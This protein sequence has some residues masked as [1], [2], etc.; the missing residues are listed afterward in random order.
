MAS[1][2][3]SSVGSIQPGKKGSSVT[4]TVMISD[5]RTSPAEACSPDA[6]RARADASA[7]L[8]ERIMPVLCNN[9]HRPGM[10]RIGPICDIT[11]LAAS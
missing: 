8:P 6:N 1:G 11:H 3:L 7:C 9:D 4:V 2:A 5:P 10:V